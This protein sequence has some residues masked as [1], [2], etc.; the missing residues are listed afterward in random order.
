MA[1]EAIPIPVLVGGAIVDSIAPCVIGVMILL[2]TVLS[3]L[4]K[5]RVLLVSGLAY[6]AG[7]YITYF[8][9]GITLLKLFDLSRE[10]V[11]FAN[12]LYVIMG[13]LI[14]FF[15]F[16][17]IKDVFWYGRGFSLSIPARFISFIETYVRKAAANKFS[18]FLFGVATTL[19]ELPCTGAPYLAVLALMSFI[20]FVETIP[21]LIL[22]NFVFI[23]PLITIIVLVYKGT[24][25]KRIEAWRSGHKRK[26]R[27]LLGLFLMALGIA[28]V[29]VL[30][31]D[32]VPYFVGV[33]AAI[34]LA[35][36]LA[37]KVRG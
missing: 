23:L 28:L 16:L 14:T 35:M 32:L 34:I 33:S 26:A 13:G 1:L 9:G 31:P 12:Y 6:I 21:Y 5:K 17:E 24:A 27:L 29:W 37:W 30:R 36:F 8:L 11:F 4:K 3:R 18:A 7:V 22:Y 2:M 25:A 19:I 10:V 15:G 20:P